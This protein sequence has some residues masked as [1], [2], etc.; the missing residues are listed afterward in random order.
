[1]VFYNLFL[2]AALLFS[3]LVLFVISSAFLGFLIT[4]VPFVPTASKDIEFIVRKLKITSKDV[5]YDLGSGNGKV[6]FLVNK[7]TNASCVGYELTIWTYALS[8]L[9]LKFIH[10]RPSFVKA[11]AG[12]QGYGGQ[13][14]PNVKFRMSDFFKADWSEANYIYGYLYPMLMGRVE[15]KFLTDCKP[16]SIAIIRDFPFPNLKPLEVFYLPKKHEVYIYKLQEKN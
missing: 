3:I 1:M 15:E 6:C 4:K 5:F 13:E 16:G 8:A 9:K 11:T 2:I 12:R 14:K 10:L 7:L